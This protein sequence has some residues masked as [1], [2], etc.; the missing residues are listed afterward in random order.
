MKNLVGCFNYLSRIV[1]DSDSPP[2]N[3][4]MALIC[5]LNLIKILQKKDFGAHLSSL[6]K[7]NQIVGF[8]IFIVKFSH[9]LMSLHEFSSKFRMEL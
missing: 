6:N 4:I 9:F 1:N 8:P 7:A 5:V 2:E 3:H